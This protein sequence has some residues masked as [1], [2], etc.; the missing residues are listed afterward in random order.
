RLAKFEKEARANPKLLPILETIQKAKSAL[1]SGKTI[2]SLLDINLEHLVDLQL[3]TAKPVIY[4]FNIDDEGLKDRQ[5]INELKLQVEPSSAIFVSA[6]L[7]NELKSLDRNDQKELL[8]SY[9][10]SKSGLEQLISEAY[11]K[12]GLQSFLTAGA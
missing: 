9:G 2:N 11:D 10:F 5:K 4:L 12:L 8:D 1:D 3:I 7:E 6:K